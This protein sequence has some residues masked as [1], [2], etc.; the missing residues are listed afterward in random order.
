MEWG[1]QFEN[2]LSFL[3]MAGPPLQVINDQPL[4]YFSIYMPSK[5]KVVVYLCCCILDKGE[6]ASWSLT[7]HVSIKWKFQLVQHPD[8]RLNA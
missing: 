6:F 7:V 8:T 4:T 1:G 2:L 5:A 3:R